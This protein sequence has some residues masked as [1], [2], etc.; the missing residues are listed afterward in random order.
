MKYLNNRVRQDHRNIKQITKPMMGFKSFNPVRRALRGI[1][2][3]SLL[4]KGK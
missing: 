3:V 2:A 1:E 4:R